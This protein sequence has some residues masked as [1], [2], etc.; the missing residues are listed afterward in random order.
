[1]KKKMLVALF[2]VMS[3]ASASAYY[4]EIDN[5]ADGKQATDVKAMIMTPGG[6]Q[7]SMPVN[8]GREKKFRKLSAPVQL[9]KVIGTNGLGAGQTAF[10]KIPENMLGKNIKIDVEI[11][12]NGKM[13][14]KHDK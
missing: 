11:D 6:T 1:M 3:V 2:A 7:I 5:D 8:S 10:F 13:Y 9:V 12:D 4:I 14:L